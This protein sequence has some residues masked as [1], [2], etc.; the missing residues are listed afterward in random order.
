MSEV[1]NTIYSYLHAHPRNLIYV[2]FIPLLQVN[3][4]QNWFPELSQP[5]KGTGFRIVRT[6]GSDLITQ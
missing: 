4:A 6:S 5:W 3:F 1:S 2:L